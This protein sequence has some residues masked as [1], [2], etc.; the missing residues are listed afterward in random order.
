MNQ[1][2]HHHNFLARKSTGEECPR[3]MLGYTR[4]TVVS[5]IGELG[6]AR[7]EVSA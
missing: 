5:I 1:S 2:I 6:D 4:G 3:F 7:C